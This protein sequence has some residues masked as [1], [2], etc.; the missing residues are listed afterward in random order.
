MNRRSAGL[1]G[2]VLATWGTACVT[3]DGPTTPQDPVAPGPPTRWTGTATFTDETQ[4]DNGG[5]KDHFELEVTWI[6]AENP[7]PAPPAGTTRYVPSGRVRA[8]I[9]SH[10]DLGGTCTV[11][12][13]AEFPLAVTDETLYPEDQVLDLGP[14]G[15]YQGKLR[16]G[17]LLEYVQFCPGRA[18]PKRSMV[19]VR[20]DIGGSV[21]GSRMHGSM[22]PRVVSNSALTSTST[23]SW[24]F[25]GN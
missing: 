13:D 12:R 24:S 3:K 1:L 25:T 10:V 6:K 15:R 19:H 23:G 2:L 21:D 4:Y 16:G 14:D 22:P 9:Q 7:S 17:W 18:F 20:L 5:A 8:R 11:D